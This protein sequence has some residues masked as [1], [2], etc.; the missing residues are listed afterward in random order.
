MIRRIENPPLRQLCVHCKWIDCKCNAVKCV[1]EISFG[2]ELDEEL[3]KEND[4]NK[5]GSK[6]RRKKVPKETADVNDT[7]SGKLEHVKIHSKEK[8]VLSKEYRDASK[9]DER[10]FMKWLKEQINLD[11]EKNIKIHSNCDNFSQSDY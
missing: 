5:N 7:T 11:D 8:S 4:A 3:L 10:M 9:F 6:I 2:F 1:S